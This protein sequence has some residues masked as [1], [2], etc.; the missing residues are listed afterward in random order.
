MTYYSRK[1]R[2]SFEEA[3]AKVTTNL[4]QRGFSIVT[5]L[6]MKGIFWQKLGEEF[7]NYKILVACNASFAFNAIS[8]ESHVGVMLPCNIVVQEHENEEIE[9]S[10]INPLENIDKTMST[11]SLVELASDVTNRLRGAI[12]DLRKDIS[13]VHAEA[14]AYR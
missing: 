4:Q 3:L 8:L 9:V 11:P 2:I 6:D 14:I 7:R 12:D 5:T 10:A 13:D 1:L